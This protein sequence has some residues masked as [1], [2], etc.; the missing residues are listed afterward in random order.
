MKV[1]QPLEVGEDFADPLPEMASLE[2]TEPQP[3]GDYVM[4]QDSG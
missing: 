1:E 3:D 2:Q 4:A